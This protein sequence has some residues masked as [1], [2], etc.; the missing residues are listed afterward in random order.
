[1]FWYL[2]YPEQGHIVICLEN[3]FHLTMYG[4][5]PYLVFFRYDGHAVSLW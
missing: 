1:M 2:L 3:N 4:A 5:V